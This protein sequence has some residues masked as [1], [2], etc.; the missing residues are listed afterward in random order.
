[1]G[2]YLANLQK[3]RRMRKHATEFLMSFGGSMIVYAISFQRI[4]P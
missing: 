1:M 4:R 2:F 3:I